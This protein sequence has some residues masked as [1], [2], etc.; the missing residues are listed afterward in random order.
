MKG[1]LN[2]KFSMYLG[3]ATYKILKM[4]GKNGTALPG[5]VSI[6]IE[7]NL[8]SEMG[9]KCDRIIIVTGTN[10]KTTINN[11]LNHV[12]KGQYKNIA[13]NLNGSNLISGVVTPFIVNKQ[14]RYD[15]GVF[16]ADEGTVP[17]VTEQ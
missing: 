15:C 16:E 13:S 7:P 8:L 12:L 11:L 1:H 5:K 6:K 3:K 2:S 4:S 9:N 14:D 17:K 10:G